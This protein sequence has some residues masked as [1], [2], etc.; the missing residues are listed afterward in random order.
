LERILE[1]LERILERILTLC[2]EKAEEAFRGLR[3][4]GRSREAT[5]VTLNLE[6]IM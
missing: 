2:A 5:L 1:I 3:E 6:E 4:E